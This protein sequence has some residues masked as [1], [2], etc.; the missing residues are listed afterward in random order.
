MGERALRAQRGTEKM[1]MMITMREQKALSLLALFSQ[2]AA[3]VQ[4]KVRP[5]LCGI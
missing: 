1:M 4:E 2:H 3:A 5:A